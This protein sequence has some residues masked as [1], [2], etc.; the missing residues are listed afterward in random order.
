MRDLR[1]EGLSAHGAERLLDEVIAIE[2]AMAAVKVLVADRAAEGSGWRA[3]GARSAEEDLAR[4]SG[5]S[6]AQA[7]EVLAT[8]KRVQQ[9][10][11]VED[12]LRDGKL[13]ERQASMIADAAAANPAAED[14]LLEAAPRTILGGLRDTCGRAKAAGIADPEATRVRLHRERYLRYGKSADG[15]LSGSFKL[16]PEAGAHFDALF[17]PFVQAEA[18][19]AR[20]EH[21][22]DTLDQLSADALVTLARRGRTGPDKTTPQVNVIVDRDALLRGTAKATSA[23]STHLLRADLGAG[24]GGAGDPRRR[25]PGR[26]VPRRHRRASPDR[27]GRRT[28]AAVRDALRV[29]DDFTCTVPGCNRRARLELDHREPVAQGGPDRYTNLEH[30]CP[31]TTTQKTTRPTA[32]QPP[33]PDRHPDGRGA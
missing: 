3:R 8:S 24:A 18:R 16:A 1:V 2:K 6:T 13:S 28:P 19:R 33:E 21:R 29:R 20:Q 27:F 26:D 30:L 4:R 10:P 9:Q 31:T 23:A 11:K 17:H 25:L 22:P 15:S 12:A 32:N 5:T 14:S 7:K